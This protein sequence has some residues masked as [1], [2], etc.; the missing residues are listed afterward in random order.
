MMNVRKHL[1]NSSV[2]GIDISSVGD[3]TV[4]IISNIDGGKVRILNGIKVNSKEEYDRLVEYITKEFYV[5]TVV[6][7]A[8]PVFRRRALQKDMHDLEV[9]DNDN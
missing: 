1:D 2:A 4:A 6:S 9:N 8:T 3:T 7:E 5:G